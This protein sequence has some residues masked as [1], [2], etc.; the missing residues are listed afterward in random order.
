MVG[1]NPTDRKMWL[2]S[3]DC[4]R[5]SE[6][7]AAN[8]QKRWSGRIAFYRRLPSKSRGP[9]WHWNP[10]HLPEGVIEIGI[11]RTN[12]SSKERSSTDQADFRRPHRRAGVE[13]QQA[14]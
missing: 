10:H 4:L 2:G 8:A 13:A 5:T 11:E 12:D 6:S 7:S 1:A 3:S 9:G 14:S